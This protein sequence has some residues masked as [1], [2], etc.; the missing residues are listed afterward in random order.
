[1]TFDDAALRPPDQGTFRDAEFCASFRLRQHTTVAQPVV[2]KSAHQARQQAL[3]TDS[4]ALVAR[5][6]ALGFDTINALA[7]LP[8]PSVDDTRSEHAA[9]ETLTSQIEDQAKLKRQAEHEIT[10]AE[11]EIGALQASGTIASDASLAEARSRRASAWKPIKSAYVAGQLPDDATARLAVADGLETAIVSADELADRRAAEAE[12]AAS[13]ALAL[14][15]VEEARAS[16][17]AAE[18]ETTAFVAQGGVRIAQWENS[19]PHVLVKHPELASLLQFVQAR[20]PVLD[21]AERLRNSANALALEEAQLAPAVELLER[22]EQSRKLDTTLSF[23]A[24]VSAVQNAISR[25]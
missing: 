17:T 24:R 3:D 4:A 7:T 2:E 21:E 5:P 1:M 13:L 12:R 9:R 19:F 18:A 8:C 6:K 10:A 16:V 25:H 11:A 14:R 15:R 23:A 20:Q 22:I